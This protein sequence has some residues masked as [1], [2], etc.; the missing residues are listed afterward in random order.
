MNQTNVHD[1]FHGHGRIEYSTPQWLFDALNA[2]FGFTL[3]AAASPDNA[4][5]KRFFTK[6]DC[7]LEKDWGDEVVWC[8]PP[9]G[10]G[11][12]G[13]WARKCYQAIRGGATV[14]MLVPV[15]ADAKWFHDYAMKG[16]VRLFRNRLNFNNDHGA[17]WYAPFAS[18]VVVFRP[19][20]FALTSFPDVK[21]LG[22]RA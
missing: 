15:R 16:E 1:Y 2:E 5:C 4:K 17:K 21:E 11:V 22:Y 19:A 10:K 14:V 7:G 6:D 3:D 8:N 12:T 20:N 9:Y 18:A 13:V